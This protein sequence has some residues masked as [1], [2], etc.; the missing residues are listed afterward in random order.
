[1]EVFHVSIQQ[2][3]ESNVAQGKLSRAELLQ[4]I[5]ARHGALR[6]AGGGRASLAP[7]AREPSWNRCSPESRALTQSSGRLPSAP[8]AR[9]CAKGGGGEAAFVSS[10]PASLRARQLP[11]QPR[12][13]GLSWASRLERR[14]AHFE[15]TFG[16]LK[17]KEGQR[18]FAEPQTSNWRKRFF[19]GAH[20]YTGGGDSCPLWAPCAGCRLRKS[21]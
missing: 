14:R 1:M 18:H 19:F 5:L 7:R 2:C 6:A 20:R 15:L 11:G 12:E 8:A 3:S 21:H 16:S 13:A 17:T 9:F 4:A 10:Q